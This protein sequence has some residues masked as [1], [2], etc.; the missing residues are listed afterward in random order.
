MGNEGKIMVMG[1]GGSSGSSASSSDTRVT[2]NG[3]LGGLLE[4]IL[5]GSF[6]MSKFAFG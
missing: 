6:R 2:L 1:L 3:D 5:S 4:A